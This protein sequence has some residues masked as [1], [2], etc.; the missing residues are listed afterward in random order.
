MAAD[1]GER[2]SRIT[3]DGLVGI[4]AG[5]HECW[6]SMAGQWTNLGL[7]KRA[8]AVVVLD[9]NAYVIR[10]QRS[11]NGGVCLEEVVQLNT[12]NAPIAAELQEDFFAGRGHCFGD[13]LRAV[14]RGIVDL[15]SR[16][17]GSPAPA[18]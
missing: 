11:L 3:A 16:S 1:F 18:S 13:L 2:V 6:S 17:S 9:V 5:M 10:L 4:A 15:E 8:V 7:D 12:W 14:R